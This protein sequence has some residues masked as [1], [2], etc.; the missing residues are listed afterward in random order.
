MTPAL[1]QTEAVRR[2]YER[3]AGNY[4]RNVKI[5][6]RLLFAGGREWVCAQVEGEVLEI[7]VGTGRNLPYYPDGVRL[8]GIEFV[9]AM[10]DVARRRAV[11]L[12]RP[13][14]LR[15]GDAQALEFEDATFDTVVCT[16]SLCTI[17]DDRA[18]VAEVRAGAPSRRTL[19]AARARTQSGPSGPGR[20]AA[21]S[22]RR[23]F[24]SEPTMC[25]AS[26]SNSPTSRPAT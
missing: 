21:C 11:E 15:V 10:L 19:R 3:E 7:A 17:P 23:S 6:E 8:T 9:P 1:E 20:P 4:D 12:G 16:L 25:C 24:A 18:A 14:E 5:P 13:V 26:R 22:R 2:V